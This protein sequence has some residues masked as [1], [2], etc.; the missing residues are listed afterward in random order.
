MQ[1]FLCYS[2]SYVICRQTNSSTVFYHMG[3][4]LLPLLYYCLHFLIFCFISVLYSYR[5]KANPPLSHDFESVVKA[6]PYYSSA[7][8]HLYRNLVETYGT[9]YI[10]QVYLGGEMKAVTSIKTCQAAMNGLSATDV[11]DCL[12]VEASVNF[13]SSASIKTMNKNCEAMKRKLNHGQS[14]SST[15]SERF[16]EIIG[17]HINGA[18]ILFQGQSTS[19]MTDWVKSLKSIPDVVRYNIKPMHMILPSSHYAIAGLKLEVEKYIKKNALMKKC[20]ETCKI[21][22]RSSRR[23]PCACV[24]NGNKNIKSNCCPAGKGR[25]T[26]KVF[27]LYAKNLYGDQCTQTD[28]S[29]ELK[30]GYQI[31]RTAIIPNNDNPSWSQVFEFGPITINTK[32]KLVL[33]VYDEDRYWNSDHLGQC[34]VK[35]RKGWFNYSCMLNHG[36]LFFS[37]KVE[38]APSLGGDYC[39]EYIP[40]PM[41]PSLAKVFHTRNGILIGETGEQHGKLVKPGLEVG[42]RETM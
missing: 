34:Q 4:I 33:N 36:T 42:Q 10:T 18:D 8:K 22:S 13:M 12:T 9:H 23:D 3:K 35:P 20:S 30:Y 28:G 37:C 19:V 38:C 31:G 6:L 39:D 1:I 2:S 24:C 41:S 21:G 5:L 26:L 16:T 11:N 27:N 17:G 29:V 15:F 40:S 14:F 25:A 32:D 7:T